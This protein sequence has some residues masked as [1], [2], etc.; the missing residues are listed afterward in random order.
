MSNQ[1]DP[2]K[3]NMAS[4]SWKNRSAT[5]R[6][7]NRPFVVEWRYGGMAVHRCG[8]SENTESGKNGQP[9]KHASNATMRC[10]KNKNLT[11]GLTLS[12]V[13]SI[14]NFMQLGLRT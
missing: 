13:R 9:T 11:R 10:Y 4:D 5:K 7:R 8:C 3:G 1:S 12:T 6:P 14:L 2:A